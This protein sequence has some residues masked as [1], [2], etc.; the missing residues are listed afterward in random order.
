MMHTENTLAE[1]IEGLRCDANTK[2]CIIFDDL[3]VRDQP[4]GAS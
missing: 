2:L 3:S 4:P 1:A